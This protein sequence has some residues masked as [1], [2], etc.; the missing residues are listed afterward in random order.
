M[1]VLDSKYFWLRRMNVKNKISRVSFA[2]EQIIRI[3]SMQFALA[4]AAYAVPRKWAL[5]IAN[6]LSLLLVILPNPGFITYLRIRSAFGKSR[7]SSLY[8]TWDCLARIFR[9]FVILKRIIY[10]RENP[11]NWRIV[12]KNV[13]GINSLRKTSEP[14]IIATGQ[15][16]KR[17]SLSV[18]SPEVTDGH[19][20]VV[21]N[22]PVERIRCLYDLRLRIQYGNLVKATYSCWGRDLEGVF[23]GNNLSTGRILNRRLHERG[24]IVCIAVDAPWRETLTGSY[25]RPFA[26]W[27]SRWFSTG[28][29]QLARL[30]QCPII[31]CVPMEESDGT[32]VLEWGVPI[33]INGS[34][35]NNDV[36]L[37]NKLLDSVEVA[38]GERPMQYIIDIGGERRWNSKSK[39]WE[40]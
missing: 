19:L 22:A 17:L 40:D 21:G 25:N 6:I 18:F 39:R 32:I 27:R 35:A 15:F 28:A 34:E 37:M 12:E 1:T 14:Y 9:D 20:V 33:R 4:P 5:S 24:N 26:G 38:I 8:L 29:A 23:V 7:L 31:S 2:L 11:L 13:D 3:L 10:K 30:A 36:N 16:A